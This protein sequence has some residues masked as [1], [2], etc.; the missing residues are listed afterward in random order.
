MRKL[1]VLF[2]SSWYPSREHPTL[3]NFIQ[4]HAEAVNPFVNL[5]VL[6]VTSSDKCKNR[7][8]IEYSNINGVSTTIV[9][10]KKVKNKLPVIS[11]FFKY[12]RSKKAYQKGYVFLRNNRNIAKFDITHCNITYPAGYFALQLKKKESIPYVISENWTVFLPY[13]NEYYSF[14]FIVRKAI[15]NIVENANLMLPVSHHLANSMAELGLK[16]KYRV[17]ANVVETNLFKVKH[18]VKNEVKNILHVS[19][20]DESQKNILGI[21]RTLKAISLVRDDF[22]L[23]IVSDGDINEAKQLLLESKLEERYVDF[24][25]TKTPE[26]I[27]KYYQAADFFL[28][29]SNYENLPCVIVESMSCGLPVVSSAIAGIPEHINETNGILVEAKNESQLKDAILNMLDNYNTY[30]RDKIREY[31]IKHFD[32]SSVGKQFLEVYK[33]VLS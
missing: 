26:E 19:T 12:L 3:G 27:V 9:Y 24:V 5:E 22:K 11:F 7:F 30:D 28:L 29:F 15:K 33:E 17:V 21:F 31:A 16:Q 20:M 2:I 6:Y 32:Y 13:R 8:E 10:Y 4:K 18:K 14:S 25:G 1:N 23:T